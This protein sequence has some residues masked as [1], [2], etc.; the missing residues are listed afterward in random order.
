MM[1]SIEM[2]TVTRNRV[3]QLAFILADAKGEAFT[4]PER[5]EIGNYIDDN[6][7]GDVYSSLIIKYGL[8]GTERASLIVY[9]L[10]SAEGTVKKDGD[11]LLFQCSEYGMK[12]RITYSWDGATFEVLSAKEGPF[13]KGD[14]FHFPTAF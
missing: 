10:G 1:Y 4:M 6:G 5:A 12:A 11:T 8:E 9:K 13:H 7:T 14:I 2:T 3:Y